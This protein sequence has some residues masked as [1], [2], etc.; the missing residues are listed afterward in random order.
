VKK[1]RVVEER[2]FFRRELDVDVV[3]EYERLKEIGRVPLNQLRDR[4]RL[5][6]EL[7]DA[8]DNARKAD[9]LRLKARRAYERHMVEHNREMAVLKRKAVVR[10]N[11]WKKKFGISK[12][13]TEGMVVEKICEKEDTRKPYEELVERELEMRDMHD[14]CK[15]LSELWDGRRFALNSQANLLRSVI[16]VNLGDGEGRKKRKK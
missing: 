7:N 5:L 8:Q 1:K 12:Q 16:E 2:E 15:R 14:A 10:I 9:T 3:K 4:E 13:I 11:A 6:R